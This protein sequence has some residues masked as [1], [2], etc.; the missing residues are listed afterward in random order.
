MKIGFSTS[1]IQRGKTGVAQ[2]VF[3]LLKAFH[4]LQEDHQFVLFVLEEDESFFSH[5]RDRF[6][7]ELVSEKFRP[8]IKNIIWHQSILPRLAKKHRLDVVHVPSYRRL[9]I[10]APCA[11]VGTIH[12]LA[13]FR[14]P[15][16]YDLARMF[17]GRVIVK[18]LAAMQD[19]L[20]AVSGNTATDLNL[21]FR[22]GEERVTVVRNGL[23]HDRFHPHDRVDA[24]ALAR[25]R[26]GLSQPYLLYVA[27]LEH[28][29]KNHI[30]LIEAFEEFQKQSKSD[31]V[32][33]LGGSDWHGA[34]VIH[35]RIAQS[36]ARD[37]IRVLGFVADQDLPALYSAAKAFIYPSLYEGFGMPPVEAMACG[38]PVICSDRGSLG[39]V[40]GDAAMIVQP[41]NP[42]SIRN[43]IL[44]FYNSESLRSEYIRKGL[45]RAAQY[46]WEKAARETLA[47]YHRAMQTRPG[48]T[49]APVPELVEGAK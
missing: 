40:V 6:Q 12:D 20:I 39:E 48:S 32:L 7:I 8:P 35:E 44:T 29:G 46:S 10:W 3:A 9:P 37:S 24:S 36:P 25:I 47:V 41:E 1:V 4:E 17:Y 27:R 21:F 13:P 19:Q 2:Y 34:E 42:D 14:V 11:R 26:F 49:P 31:W 33:A 22:L 5:L 28:P 43:A 45:A 16:K 38:C 15:G 18:R 30:R 23:D